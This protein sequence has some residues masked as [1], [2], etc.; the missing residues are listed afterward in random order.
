MPG[1]ARKGREPRSREEYLEVIESGYP[2]FHPPFTSGGWGESAMFQ[3]PRELAGFCEYLQDKP[4]KKYLEVGVGRG[5]LMRFMREVMGYEVLGV[6]STAWKPLALEAGCIILGDSR[7][8][9]TLARV[10]AGAPYDLV[11]IDADHSYESARLDYQAY[12]GFS[13][14]F[15]ALHDVAYD[16]EPGV[17]RLWGELRGEKIAFVD[18]DPAMRL[19][20]GLLPADG[21]AL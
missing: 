20:I 15:V 8:P 17:V 19:G 12:R 16:P 10:E 11:F 14:L 18:P 1:Q 5:M 13:R 7:A 9:E 2:T 4:V 21:A 3:N 6:E